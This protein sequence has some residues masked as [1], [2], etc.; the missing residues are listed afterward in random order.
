MPSNMTLITAGQ[1]TPLDANQKH[2]NNIGRIVE[3]E[4]ADDRSKKINN[5][6]DDVT[7][8]NKQPGNISRQGSDINVVSKDEQLSMGQAAS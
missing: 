4:G 6:S 7:E 3:T 1:A 5:T 2:H 8:M